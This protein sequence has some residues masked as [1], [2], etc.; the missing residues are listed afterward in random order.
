M[1]KKLYT[2]IGCLGAFSSALYPGWAF[3]TCEFKE[4]SDLSYQLEIESI[5]D[6]Q[7]PLDKMFGLQPVQGFWKEKLRTLQNLVLS[8]SKI[9]EG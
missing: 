2:L 1:F 3:S 8:C 9:M 5:E 6:Y 7:E 4:Q